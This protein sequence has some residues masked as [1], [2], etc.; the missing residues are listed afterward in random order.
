MV[1]FGGFLTA[2]FKPY[3]L[4]SSES[5]IQSAKFQDLCQM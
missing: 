2:P 4:T 5:N 1:Q 3:A